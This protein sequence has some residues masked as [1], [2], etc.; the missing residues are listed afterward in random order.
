MVEGMMQQAQNMMNGQVVGN[1]QMVNPG[2]API[3]TPAP[4]SQNL[5]TGNP[6]M[7]PGTNGMNANNDNNAQAMGVNAPNM[8]GVNEVIDNPFIVSPIPSTNGDNAASGVATALETASLNDNGNSN[9]Y[10]QGLATNLSNDLAVTTD[11][12][13]KKDDKEVT[14][15]EALEALEILNRYFKN[16]KELPSTLANELNGQTKEENKTS[17]VIAQQN[18]GNSHPSGEISEFNSMPQPEYVVPNDTVN[19]TVSE[20][21]REQGKTLSLVPEGVPSA[22]AVTSDNNIYNFNNQSPQESMSQIPAMGS[23]AMVAPEIVPVSEF[24]G[25][26]MQPETIQTGYVASSNGPAIDM[27]TTTNNINDV[28]VILPDNYNPQVM[29][30]NNV[31]M[32][33]GSLPAENYAKVA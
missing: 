1:S 15:E 7:V 18:M 33:P 11:I 4:V 20:I 28:P 12:T 29:A 32:G 2:V 24:D 8:Q 31:V 26:K 23:P 13:S 21:A 16:T 5:A 3:P 10:Q 17:E 25:Q 19:S 30:N 27:S 14:K 6:A 22:P 9:Q